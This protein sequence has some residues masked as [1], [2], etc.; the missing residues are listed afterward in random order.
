MVSDIPAGD[1]KIVKLFLQCSHLVRAPSTYSEGHK[2][3]FF[4]DLPV[5]PQSSLMTEGGDGRGA[6]S[7]DYEPACTVTRRKVKFPYIHMMAPD[8]NG[9]RRENCFPYESGVNT[10]FPPAVFNTSG[11]FP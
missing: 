1:G 10:C 7:C 5:S 6:K 3:S 11:I 8:D 2:F 9:P 4:L